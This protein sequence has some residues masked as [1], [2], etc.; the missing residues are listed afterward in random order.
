MILFFL[1]IGRNQRIDSFPKRNNS[2][3]MTGFLVF[4]HHKKMHNMS[5]S[6]FFPRAGRPQ[7]DAVL[8][9]PHKLLYVGRTDLFAVHENFAVKRYASQLGIPGGDY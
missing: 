4:R 9:L 8:R 3:Y 1:E 7:I 2:A 5:K 6:E